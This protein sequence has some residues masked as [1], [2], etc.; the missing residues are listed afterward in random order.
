MWLVDSNKE[1]KCVCVCVCV[2]PGPFSSAASSEAA[3]EQ[4]QDL[5]A[6]LES[7]KE[8]EGTLRHGLNIFKIVQPPSKDLQALEKVSCSH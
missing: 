4:I 2:C 7:Q 5:R 1:F 6:Q 3:L 8:E